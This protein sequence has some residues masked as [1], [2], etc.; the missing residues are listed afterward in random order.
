LIHKNAHILDREDADAAEIV[1]DAFLREGMKIVL[2][3]S[4]RSVETSVS[5]KLLRVD[6]EG[7]ADAIEVDRILI[8]AARAP[9]VIGMGLEAA[10]VA[11]DA[12][13]GVIVNDRLQT[14]RPHIYSAGDVAMRHKLTHVAVAAARIVIQNALFMGR[15]KLSALT[16]PWATYTDPEIAHVGL[17]EREAREM[18]MEVD[19]YRRSFDDMDRAIADGDEEGFVKVHT[20]KG[21][22][23]IVGATIVARHAGDMISEITAAMAGGLGLKGLS[24]V[25]HPYPTQAEA[26][27]HA[28]DI[29]NRTRLTPGLK[30]W[31]TKWFSWTR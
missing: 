13:R 18:G 28:G 25:I 2:Q 16:V 30:R 15:K 14:S 20:E 17:Y 23:R 22:D 4:V 6:H 24:G 19:T 10:G 29:Y 27:K 1:Q 7:G 3:A 12:R 21:T 31:F 5:G 11:Y 9:N 8:G 26:I